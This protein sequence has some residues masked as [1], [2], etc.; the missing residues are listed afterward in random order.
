MQ[1]SPL[2][3]IVPID[4][5]ASGR[6]LARALPEDSLIQLQRMFR[7]P[8]LL[9]ADERMDLIQT[10]QAGI[11]VAPEVTELRVLLGMAECVDY[12][13]QSGMETLREA[14]RREPDNFL[15]QLKLGELLMRLRV[16]DQAVKHTDLAAHLAANPIQSELA[17]RQAATLRTMLREGIERDG[18]THPLRMIKKWFRQ[19]GGRKHADIALVGPS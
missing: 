8:H 17:R 12:R 18:V 13:V 10:L 16:C 1:L 14:V 4:L 19:L 15:A 2:S 3:E 11:T 5:T 6:A 7:D 9:S